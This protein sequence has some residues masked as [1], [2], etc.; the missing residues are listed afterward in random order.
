M[1]GNSGDMVGYERNAHWNGAIWRYQNLEWGLFLPFEWLLSSGWIINAL[2]A[3][4]KE[5]FLPGSW[6]C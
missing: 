3:R 4:I 1:E 5:S 2:L 6:C